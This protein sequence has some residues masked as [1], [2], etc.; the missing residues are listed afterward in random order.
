MTVDAAGVANVMTEYNARLRRYLLLMGMSAKSL[1]PQVV[2]P[3]P[4]SPSKW[5]QSASA[6]VAR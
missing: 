3:T 2:D 5:R 1:A 4:R 6:S